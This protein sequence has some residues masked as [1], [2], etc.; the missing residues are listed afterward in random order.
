MAEN[1][2]CGCACG[3]EQINVPVT[4]ITM[5]LCG[6]GVNIDAGSLE[7][8]G[9]LSREEIQEMIDNSL[10]RYKI[11]PYILCEFYTFRHPVAH[12]GFAPAQGDVIENAADLYPAAWAYLQTEKGRMLC[13]TEEEWQAMT[14]ATWATLADGTKIGW[15]GIGG[16]PFYVQDLSA[17][18]LRL[19]DLRG[20]YAEAAGF[21]SLG[22]GGVHGD[23]IRN[24][25]GRV[26]MNPSVI[27]SGD[28]PSGA[29]WGAD[30]LP[31]V[32]QAITGTSHFDSF[33]FESGRVAPYANKNQPRAWGAL[34]CVYLGAPK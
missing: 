9:G 23:A 12:V 8:L 17:G 28:A 25:T 10:S 20:M 2:N 15:D 13:K 18:T 33:Y 5:P 19:P 26:N 7:G 34:A 29:F 22:V 6:F 30:I 32:A 31:N 27:D 16:V 14:H 4:G 11:D 21:D 1:K 3:T 24:I